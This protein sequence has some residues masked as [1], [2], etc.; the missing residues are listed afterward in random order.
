MIKKYML[1][2]TPMC[3]KCPKIKEYMNTKDL[4]KEWVDAATA[5]GLEKAREFG[6]SGVPTIIF[7]NE[8]GEEVSRATEIEE[9]KRIVENKTLN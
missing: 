5:D 4:E 7:F 8:N 9:V 2:F 3:P 6:V 1:F